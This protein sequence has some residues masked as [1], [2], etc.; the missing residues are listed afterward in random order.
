MSFTVGIIQQGD[1]PEIALTH[2]QVTAIGFTAPFDD[3]RMGSFEQSSA[4]G[5][6]RFK[7]ITVSLQLIL[8]FDTLQNQLKGVRVRFMTEEETL[9][10]E[11]LTGGARE[12]SDHVVVSSAVANYLRLKV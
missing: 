2:A 8:V 5:A 4:A 3:V 11:S 10:M 9:R 1:R 12:C 6:V 7:H